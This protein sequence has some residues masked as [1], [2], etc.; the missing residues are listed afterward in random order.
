M[1]NNEHLLEELKPEV[2]ERIARYFQD[3][4]FVSDLD[5]ALLNELMRRLVVHSPKR[6]NGRKHV[7]IEVYFT[8]AGKIRIPSRLGGRP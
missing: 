1:P 8:Y 5:A 2:V 4:A 6:I 7:T 3:G